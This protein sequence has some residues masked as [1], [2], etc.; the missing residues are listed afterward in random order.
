MCKTCF[1]VCWT[2]H[3]HGNYILAK[4][5]WVE[6]LPVFFLLDDNN[7]SYVRTCNWRFSTLNVWCI[8]LNSPSIKTGSTLVWPL[9]SI[10]SYPDDS[11]VWASC[12][13][14]SL[15]ASPN[16]GGWIP[17]LFDESSSVASG[18]LSRTTQLSADFDEETASSC[19]VVSGVFAIWSWCAVCD[20][21]MISS[22]CSHMP[23]RS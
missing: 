5:L 13:I 3:C 18:S 21:I 4:T 22:S 12:S 2:R 11:C 10:E 7:Y 17:W 9:D 8:L 23:R 1:L 15:V 20:T 14:P 19:L 6:L 16:A